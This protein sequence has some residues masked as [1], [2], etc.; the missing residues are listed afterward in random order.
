MP[1]AWAS[2][3]QNLEEPGAVM[4]SNKV[5]SSAIVTRKSGKVRPMSATSPNTSSPIT[6]SPITIVLADDHEV[7]RRGLRMTILGEA[8]MRLVAEATNGQD[9]VTAVTNHQPDLVLLDV[10]MPD[11]DGVRAA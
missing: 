9:A 7:V 10:Q 1:E 5:R 2:C 6:D 3:R 4:Q 8:D 11:M